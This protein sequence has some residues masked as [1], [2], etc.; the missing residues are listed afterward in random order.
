MGNTLQETRKN[1]GYVDPF[2]LNFCPFAL[3]YSV[4]KLYFDRNVTGDK[5]EI[6]DLIWTMPKNI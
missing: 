3:S 2:R 5:N 6:K 1:Q 4:I